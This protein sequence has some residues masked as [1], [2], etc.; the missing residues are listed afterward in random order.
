MEKSTSCTDGA[1]AIMVDLIIFT[2]MLSSTLYLASL[3]TEPRDSLCRY[4][5]N[6]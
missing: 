6:S 5:L 2:R 3:G 4:S 1:L